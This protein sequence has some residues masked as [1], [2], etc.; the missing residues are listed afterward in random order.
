M[1]MEQFCDLIV[2]VVTQVYTCDNMA[3]TPPPP[4]SARSGAV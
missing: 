3:Q 4:T 2:A 1:E